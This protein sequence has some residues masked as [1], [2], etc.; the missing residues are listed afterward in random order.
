MG[1]ATV[2]ADERV[3]SLYDRLLA[4]VVLTQRGGAAL[5]RPG[6]ALPAGALPFGRRVLR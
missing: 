4:G 5:F 3:I 1:L 6:N 2:R